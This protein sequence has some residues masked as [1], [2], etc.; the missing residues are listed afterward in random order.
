MPGTS[1]HSPDFSSIPMSSA[2]V[3][4]AGRRDSAGTVDQRTYMRPLMWLGI[5]RAS[6]LCLSRKHWETKY[7]N[8]PKQKLPSLILTQPQNSYM[9]I[10]TIFYWLQ[11][12]QPRCKWKGVRSHFLMGGMSHHDSHVLKLPHLLESLNV[13]DMLKYSF[14]PKS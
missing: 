13:S 8:R 3:W 5:L 14:L 4:M 2:L 10:S 1:V 7:S 9:L 12:G 6:Q 11:E